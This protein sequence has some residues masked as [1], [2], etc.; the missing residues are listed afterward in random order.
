MSA[1]D[2]NRAHTPEMDL[3]SKA[4]AA[5]SDDEDGDGGVA[6]AGS[7]HSHPPPPPKRVRGSTSFPN[8]SQ[9]PVFRLPSFPAEAPIPGS[10]ISKRQRASLVSDPTLS[11]P[12][13]THADPSPVVGSLSDSD[14]PQCVFTALRRRSKNVV[15][16]NQTPQS[17]SADLR[18]HTKAVNSLQWSKSHAHLLASAGMDHTVRIWNVWSTGQKQASAFNN[19][20]A[21]VKDVKWSEHGLSF[22]SCG[23]DCT[24]RLVDVE[25]GM[26]IKVFKE[27]QIV[28]VVKFCPDN[29]NLF[30]SGGSKGQLKLW[31]IRTGMVVHEYVRNLGPIL[32]VDFTVDGKYLITSSDVSQTNLSENSIIVWDVSRQV[33][34]SNQVYAEAFTC[35]C[36]RCH[37]FEP[38]FIAQSNGNYIAIFSTRPPFKLDKYKRY[39]SHSVSGFPIKCNFSPDGNMVASG[40][41]DGCIY[42][43]DS[44]SS[45]FLKKVKV[46]EQACIDIVFHPVLHDVI[47][48]CSWS[49]EV[50][51]LQARP[52]MS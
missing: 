45:K 20:H 52:R 30:L 32:D 16:S 35:P 37:P 7:R 33:P 46:Y 18:G 42:Y 2:R 3:L 36:I 11:E 38:Y 14:L 13:P 29:Y 9:M 26:E 6:G 47:A 51:V 8:S 40:S 27:N 10:Y 4:Y 12:N 41:S 5:A 44:K 43:F 17:L 19:H 50:S 22:L 49:G 34:L 25:K 23:Y 1:V 15:V 21:A 24:S 39:E 48:S 28:E 31:D